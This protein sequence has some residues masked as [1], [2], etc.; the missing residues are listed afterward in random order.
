MT[1]SALS[2]VSAHTMLPDGEAKYSGGGGGVVVSSGSASVCSSTSGDAGSATPVWEA[3]APGSPAPPVSRPASRMTKSSTRALTTTMSR[4]W[5]GVSLPRASSVMWVPFDDPDTVRDAARKP[6]NSAWAGAEDC[7]AQPHHGR[8]GGNGDV[9]VSTH[10]HGQLHSVAGARRPAR[11][12]LVP[13]PRELLVG[14]AHDAG[15]RGVRPDR[16]EP[17]QP[18]VGQG[19][20]LRGELQGLAGRRA[21]LGGL[22]GG[23][24]LHE[25]LKHPA[26]LP[27]QPV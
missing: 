1:Q 12:D 2:A 23:V 20:H 5:A 13:Q 14:L 21:G 25:H 27:G 3:S 6:E 11:R 8:S 9:Q 10:P 4:I 18:Q 16:H 24:D 19:A 26:G 22:L 17:A 7:G 15:V